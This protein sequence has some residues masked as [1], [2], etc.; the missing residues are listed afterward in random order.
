MW[1][2]NREAQ[3][4][5]DAAYE[6]AM[7]K[8]AAARAA[9][10]AAWT[11]KNPPGKRRKKKR[12]APAPP[13]P[14]ID[15]GSYLLSEWWAWVRRRKLGR[16]H[17]CERCGARATLVHHRHYRSLGRESDDDLESLCKPC[18]EAEHECLVTAESHLRSIQ[19]SD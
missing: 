3:R 13:K 15:Y 14:G 12:R 19:R 17:R 9:K 4:Q 1:N 11:A 8:R 7:R 2:G 16:R 10:Q 5:A 6:A 18:H